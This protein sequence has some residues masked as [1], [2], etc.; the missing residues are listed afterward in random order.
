MLTPD[1]IRLLPQRKFAFPTSKGREIKGE[2]WP[3]ERQPEQLMLATTARL[4]DGKPFALV[5][6]H[7]VSSRLA[8]D[9]LY[10]LGEQ[11]ETE[12]TEK[13]QAASASEPH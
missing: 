4:K 9:Q 11:L 8:P 6:M 5:R 2:Y 10:V 12:A 13:E 3:S 7:E 1:Q